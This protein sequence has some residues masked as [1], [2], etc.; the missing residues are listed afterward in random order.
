[1]GVPTCVAA[2]VTIGSA[3]GAAIGAAAGVAGLAVGAS[4]AVGR[5]IEHGGAIGVGAVAGIDA[6]PVSPPI[7]TAIETAGGLLCYWFR[8]DRK[9]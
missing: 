8:S 4:K 2:G 1:M 5:I 9:P 7:L 3:A 6:V